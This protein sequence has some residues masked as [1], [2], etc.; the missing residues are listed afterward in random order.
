MRHL[1]TE[2]MGGIN[3][4]Q[5][6]VPR[7]FYVET[8]GR[9]LTYNEII[10]NTPVISSTYDGAVNRQMV[11]GEEG[12]IPFWDASRFYPVGRLA[13]FHGRNIDVIAP[14]TVEDRHGNQFN[15]LCI[16]G[17]DMSNPEFMEHITAERDYIIRGFQES[18]VMERVIRASKILRENN[19]G[20]EYI[21]GLTLPIKFPLDK[22]SGNAFDTK[23][24]VDLPDLLEYLATDFAKK[25][26]DKS[27]KSPLEI[28]S[29]MIEKFQDCDYLISYRA[30][31]CPI[32][33]G[34]LDE[35]T[36]S[37]FKLLQPYLDA[38]RKTLSAKKREDH[39]PEGITRER[40][41]SDYFSFILGTNL[42]AMHGLGIAHGF[43]HSNNITALGSI[44]DLDSCKGEVL[45]FND[46]PRAVGHYLADVMTAINSIKSVVGNT[47]VQNDQDT[48][49]NIE[50]FMSKSLSI[51]NFLLS[52]VYAVYESDEERIDY[53]M[54]L[55]THA[56]ELFDEVNEIAHIRQS[57]YA[58]YEII[59]ENEGPS[60]SMETERL[61]DMLKDHSTPNKDSTSLSLIPSF[62]LKPLEKNILGEEYAHKSPTDDKTGAYHPFAATLHNAA[63]DQIIKII[64]NNDPSSHS[65]IAAFTKKLL[66]EKPHEKDQRLKDF[67][68]R[69]YFSQIA[70]DLEKISPEA[71]QKLAS[72]SL[73]TQDK[74]GEIQ[75]PNGSIPI[76]YLNSLEEY[77]QAI[78]ALV[79]EGEI[80]AQSIDQGEFKLDSLDKNDLII[81][82]A[83]RIKPITES[84]II[85]GIDDVFRVLKHAT[86][87]E[88]LT[89]LIVIK[90]VTSA[91]PRLHIVSQPGHG[92]NEEK[93]DYERLLAL[94]TPRFDD[95]RLF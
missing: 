21:C 81:S 95:L 78:S 36:P 45:G 35:A 28:K 88:T 20:T 90:D 91:N 24:A 31:D 3:Q 22:S 63:L 32:R 86:D 77:Q 4:T 50:K 16:K 42:G 79:G 82:D 75:S 12:D 26:A 87:F 94:I 17:T 72:S 65:L 25:E 44:V 38:A 13:S 49:D 93:I 11:L 29:E 2:P 51:R 67:V 64:D 80:S 52:Y 53:I 60:P 59:I 71:H 61:L 23:E 8:N 69:I 33:F 5:I 30:M 43:L 92:S 37:G 14:V 47:N 9:R 40:Y 27:N 56:N 85:S 62:A 54:Y 89:P 76:L 41:I 46:E 39:L 68:S 7:V 15:S 83:L 66:L 58:V 84:C 6:D 34:Q 18:L 1:E 48:Q 19:V 70:E 73:I 10:D 74:V 57:L 55:L